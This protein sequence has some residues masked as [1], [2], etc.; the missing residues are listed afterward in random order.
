[1]SVAFVDD[2]NLYRE[3]WMKCLQDV[4]DTINCVNILRELEFVIS[5]E[6]SIL[7]TTQTTVF[8]GLFI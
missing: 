5:L 6:K 3:T 7:T 4:L 2:L 8:L 1:M